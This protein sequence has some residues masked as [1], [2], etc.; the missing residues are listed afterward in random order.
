[1]NVFAHQRRVVGSV[2]IAVA[3]LAVL[4]ACD[5]PSPP[6]AMPTPTTTPMT[7]PTPAPMS[8]PNADPGATPGT[9]TP[10]PTPMPTASAAS[11]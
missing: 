4:A 11:Q 1:M 9:T 3:S 2:C 7:A 8:N 5:R 10:T 6:E